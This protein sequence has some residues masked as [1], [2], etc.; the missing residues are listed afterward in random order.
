MPP[1]ERIIIENRV[2]H[3]P[4]AYKRK[5]FAESYPGERHD[6][7][8]QIDRWACEQVPIDRI[9]GPVQEAAHEFL[10]YANA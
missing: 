5:Q 3:T 6:V 9:S 7:M 2:Y 4:S 10:R 8:R 1:R